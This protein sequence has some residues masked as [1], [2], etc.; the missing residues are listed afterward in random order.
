VENKTVFSKEMVVSTPNILARKSQEDP[1]SY[2]KIGAESEDNNRPGPLV[3]LRTF[4]NV[5]NALGI[6]L[7]EEL[8]AEI[9]YNIYIFSI[10]YVWNMT[11]RKTKCTINFLT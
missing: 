10:R 1:L 4:K 3:R 11:F 8:V 5:L 6:Y 2:H 7:C 9:N